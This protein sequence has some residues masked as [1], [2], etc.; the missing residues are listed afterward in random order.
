MVA[1]E[2]SSIIRVLFLPAM[3]LSIRS[4]RRAAAH[5]GTQR[6]TIFVL[7]MPAP[8]EFSSF[9]YRSPPNFGGS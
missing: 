1:Q 3:V 4:V 6:K 5:H 8:Q 2:I 7:V 9:T